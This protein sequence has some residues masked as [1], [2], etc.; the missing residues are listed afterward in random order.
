MSMWHERV[1]AGSSTTTGLVAVLAVALLLLFAGP[2]EAALKTSSTKCA[3]LVVVG[4]RGSG[5]AASSSSSIT[6]F[7]PQARAGIETAVKRVKRS[8]TVRYRSLTKTEY[9]AVS[10]NWTTA[11]NRQAYWASVSK[12]AK[13]TMAIVKDITSKCRST[14][15]ALVGYSQGASVVRWAIRDLPKSVR[16]RVALVGLL[17][18]P[19]RR[20]YNV[21]PSEIGIQQNYDVT[22]GGKPVVS[23][24][25][26]ALGA[27]PALPG[28]RV[29][30]I[31][32]GCH[33]DDDV[34]NLSTRNASGAKFDMKVHT[35][36]Y[37]SSTGASKTGLVFYIAL[38]KNGFK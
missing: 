2:A 26:G 16:A 17:G 6:G 32:S 11:F 30:A 25:S 19:E 4:A 15:V 36:Y 21:K 14:K 10:V 23:Y 5:Q 37:Q 3:S 8:G 27:G 22:R 12:G 20:G 31:A 24:G 33:P 35:T 13:S 34:C 29:S 7:G 9:P 38:S 18:D 28:D 1:R